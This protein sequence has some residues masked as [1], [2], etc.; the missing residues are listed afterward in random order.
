[1]QVEGESRAKTFF[2]KPNTD[3]P[4]LE[5][6]AKILT[7]QARNAHDASDDTISG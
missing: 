6:G 5:A 1:V 7:K 4:V 2:A 3:S